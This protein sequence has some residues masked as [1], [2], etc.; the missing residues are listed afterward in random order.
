[1]NVL[2]IIP[3]TIKGEIDENFNHFRLS[4]KALTKLKYMIFQII[5]GSKHLLLDFLLCIIAALLI[6]I[7]KTLVQRKP[8]DNSKE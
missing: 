5:L 2:K 4:Q 3:F 1:M 6:E 8:K 7:I